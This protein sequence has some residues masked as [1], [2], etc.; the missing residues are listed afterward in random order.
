MRQIYRAPLVEPLLIGLLVWQAT[1]GLTMFLSRVRRM[2]ASV[3][4][5]L[6][7]VSGIYIAVFLMS[8]LTAVFSTRAAG[9]DTN[10]VWLVGRAG[11]LFAGSSMTVMPHYFIGPLLVFVHVACGVR[12]V[13]LARGAPTQAADRLAMAIIALGALVTLT[14]TAGLLG[15]HVAS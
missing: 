6:Q 13:R 12:N 9:V 4:D 11:N 2:S 15:L 14:I 10:W 8:H 3:F 5:T 1:S 7:T